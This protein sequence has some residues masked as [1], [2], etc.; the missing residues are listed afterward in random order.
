MVVITGAQGL[1]L[2][3]IGAVVMICA[4]AILLGIK[5]TSKALDDES[6]RAKRLLEKIFKD[7]TQYQDPNKIKYEWFESEKN[8]SIFP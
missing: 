5:K 3:L 4:V 6:I 1:F 8:S 2:L 7:D